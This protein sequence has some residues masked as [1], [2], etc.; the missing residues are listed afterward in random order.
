MHTVKLEIT[1]DIAKRDISPLEVCRL[2][3]SSILLELEGCG[4]EPRRKYLT[5]R[6]VKIS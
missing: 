4:P 5:L 1:I 3:E 6:S 2:I